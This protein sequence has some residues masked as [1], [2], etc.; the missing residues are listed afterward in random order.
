MIQ[1]AQSEM[2]KIF[3][4]VC[5][6]VTEK[7]KGAAANKKRLEEERSKQVEEARRLAK[8][9]EEAKKHAIP[10]RKKLGEGSGYGR[11][12]GKTVPKR[13]DPPPACR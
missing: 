10:S 12:K 4:K 5:A 1:P 7:N 6:K 2:N 8:E 3:D 11:S 13:K 9:R